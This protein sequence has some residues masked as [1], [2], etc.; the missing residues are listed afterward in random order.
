LVPHAAAVAGGLLLAG[1]MGLALAA[2]SLAPYDPF[3]I[4]STPAAPPG[5]GV[6]LGTNTVGQDLFSLVLYGARTSLLVG[7]LTAGLS[8]ALSAFVG[9]LAGLWTRGRGLA[10]AVVD[11]FLAIPAVPL[12]VLLVI[13]LGAGLWPLVATLAAVSWAAFA[14][15]VHAQVEV[16]VRKEYIEAGRALGATPARLIRTG[17]LPEI[18]PIL[19]T[20]FLLTVRWAVLMEATLGVLG[21]GDPSRVSWGLVLHQAFTYPLL[22]VTNAWLWWAGPPALAIVATSLGLMAIGQD[23]DYWLNPALRLPS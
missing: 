11:L 23:L 5:P 9:V 19:S 22:F 12:V 20:K 7:F 21:L 17:I 1:I 18:A 2:P 4:V 16:T 10:A 15:V 3:R 14:R 8:T 6:L 13:F